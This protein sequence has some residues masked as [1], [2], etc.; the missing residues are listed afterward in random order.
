MK[1]NKK[2]L[3]F[4]TFDGLH[5]GH[6]FFLRQAK[7]RADELVV[8]VAR[9]V[10]VRDLKNKIP[11]HREVA[12]LN[13]VKGL[14]FVDEAYLSDETLGSFRVIEEVKPDLIVLGHDQRLLEDALQVWFVKQGKYIPIKRLKKI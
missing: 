6:L 3:V 14:S 5:S 1:R 4:G 10:H 9:D 8:S 2:A 12:R 7:T 13:I 11:E